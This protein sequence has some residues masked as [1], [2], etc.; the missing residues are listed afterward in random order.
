MNYTRIIN[1]SQNLDKGL[2]RNSLQ[3]IRFVEQIC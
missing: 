3:G 2:M 1:V